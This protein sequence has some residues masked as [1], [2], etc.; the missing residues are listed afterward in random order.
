MT[1]FW[2]WNVRGY[3]SGSTMQRLVGVVATG[4]ESSTT[5][6]V[7]LRRGGRHLIERIC[8][9]LGFALLAMMSLPSLAAPPTAPQ[10][11]VAVGDLHGDF[12][13]WRQIALKANLIDSRNRWAG[14]KSIL[15][16]MGDITDRG[17]DS[18]KI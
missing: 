3:K 5:D 4:R 16:Q 9:W 15:V 12:D 14:G 1:M 7:N 10:R 6:S 17:P 18:L 13:A 2:V 8:R 11:I